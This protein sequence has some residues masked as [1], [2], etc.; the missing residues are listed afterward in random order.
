MKEAIRKKRKHSLILIAIIIIGLLAG[1]YLVQQR[2][3][4]E[5]AQHQVENIVDYDAALRAAS[6]EKRSTA[7]ALQALK[8][9]GVTAMAIYDRTLEKA[10][11]AGEIIVYQGLDANALQFYG[12]QPTAGY[13]YLVAAHGKEG[14]FKEIQDDLVQRLGKDKVTILYSNR[15]PVIALA[16]PFEALMDMKLS[17][18]RLQAQ[19][20][21]NLGFNVIVRPTNF[22][23]VTR[24][25]VDH[26]FSR[27]DGIPNVTGMVFVGKEALGYPDFIGLTNEYLHNLRIPVVGIEAVNQLQY[28]NQ[29]GF[30]NDLA[31]AD[32]YSIGRLYTISKE[33]L[34]KLS[35]EE[36]SQ[37]FFISDIERNI[38]FNLLPIYEEGS[39]NK[40]ALATS[41]TYMNSLKEKLTDR[42]FTFGRASIYPAYMPSPLAVV[43]TMA[44]SVAL[45]TFMLNLFYPMRKYSQLVVNFTLLL[46][47]VVLYAVTGGT[48]ITQI[49][50]LSAAICAPVVAIILIM[51]CWVRRAEGPIVG[52]WRATLE[53]AVYLVGA[54]IIASIGGILI[55]A[56]LG[57]TRFFMEFSLFR[58]VKLVFVAPIILTAIAYL[59]RFPLWQGRTV[60]SWPECRSF[61]RSFL[62]LD[63]KLY[64]IIVFAFLGIVGWIFV[65]R[66]GHTAGV[67]VP[68][69][70]I[71]LRRF[72]EN[73]LYARPREKE[74][75]IGHPALMLASFAVLRRWPMV[76]HFLCTIAGVIG[77]GSMVE[78][79][80]H[81]RTPVFMSIARGYDGLLIGVVAGVVAILVFRFLAYTIAWARRGEVSND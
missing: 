6:F 53:A 42:G 55:A 27:I 39:D 8:E 5:S 20:V 19:E 11:D 36:V 22:K 25:N 21:S 34:K 26:V 1:L 4:I 76:F 45:F 71:A 7:E 66:S 15:G 62:T 79:F 24:D 54:A 58:G 9:A 77:I 48:L 49:W 72:L 50:A 65:G 29:V 69:F 73:T 30:N 38:R 52:P 74:F 57:N 61:L 32:N 43:L 56:M 31:V 17:I 18:S 81:L 13:T 16:Q 10:R 37:R 14:Y 28:E 70:E 51:D 35:P 33:E 40:T 46:I 41:I 63:V 60:D 44:G 12:T 64:M 59:Q 80:C 67:P 3:Q 75:L 47:T 68:S 78:T 23:H 2:H